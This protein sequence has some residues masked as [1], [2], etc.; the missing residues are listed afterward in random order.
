MKHSLTRCRRRRRRSYFS[1]SFGHHDGS[2]QY[3]LLWYTSL[4]HVRSRNHQRDR[5]RPPV[6]WTTRNFGTI[7]V[8]NAFGVVLQSTLLEDVT[9][10]PKNAHGTF[11]A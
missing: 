3:A 9:V 4:G 11:A 2:P 10:A 7:R 1:C 5:C 8:L 6:Q